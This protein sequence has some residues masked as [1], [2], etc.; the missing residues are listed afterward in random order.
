MPQML[1]LESCL[2]RVPDQEQ[3]ITV[4][5]GTPDVNV[6]KDQA[7]SL[8]RMGRCLYQKKADD[9]TKGHYS[10]GDESVIKLAREHAANREKEAAAAE[11]AKAREARAL[12]TAQADL[13]KAT[14]E[15]D[16]LRAELE[17][18]KAAQAEAT[19]PKA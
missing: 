18:L 11:K 6:D 16:A 9:P 14:A 13:A 12:E 5:E 1:F 17:A 7:I 15:A 3:A 8:A 2:V 19:D 10:V 4:V